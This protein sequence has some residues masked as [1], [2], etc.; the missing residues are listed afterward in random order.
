[1][2]D[3]GVVLGSEF[4]QH[5]S[6]GYRVQRAGYRG[7]KTGTEP[8]VQAPSTGPGAFGNDKFMRAVA[9]LGLVTV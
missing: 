1:V 2:I 9:V 4:E 5:G 6:T 7:W 3:D 8:R